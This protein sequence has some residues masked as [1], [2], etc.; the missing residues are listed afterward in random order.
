MTGLA[1]SKGFSLKIANI[2]LI[3]LFNI[4]REFS[5]KILHDHN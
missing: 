1:M 3:P 5:P 4:S 2:T